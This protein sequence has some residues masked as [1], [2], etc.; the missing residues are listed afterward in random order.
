MNIRMRMGSALLAAALLSGTAA[1][2]LAAGGAGAQPAVTGSISATLRVDYDQRLSALADR[3]V[4]A[5]LSQKNGPSLGDIPL[6]EEGTVAL[7]GGKTAQVL[8]RSRDGGEV[9]GTVLPGN[10]SLTVSDLPQGTYT[11]T[12]N[13][14]G[15]TTYTE[16]ITLQDYSCHLIVGTG[17]ATFT[18]GDVDGDGK[19][20]AKDQ[21]AISEA[22]GSQKREDVTRYDL[23]GDGI[24]DIIDLAYVSRQIKAQGG[25]ELASTVM[26]AP[27]VDLDALADRLT[28][29]GTTVASGSLA[30]LFVENGQGAVLI[31]QKDG[32]PVTLEITPSS[33]SQ[34]AAGLG[35]I[36]LSSQEGRGAVLAGSAQVEYSD[37]S[38]ETIAFDQ[39]LPEGVHA[40]SRT[41]G[42]NVI[43]ISL[44]KRVPVKKVTITVTKTDGGDFVSL[45]TIQFLKDIVPENPVAPNSVVRGLTAEP[46]NEQ[47]DLK[48]GPLPNVEGYQVDYWPSEDNT[49]RKSLPVDVT[50]AT[51]TGL[52]NLTEYTFVVTPT[53]EGWA[54]KAS[55][56][57]T[58]TPQPA[59]AP[60]APDM[61]S[62]TEGDGELSI[63]WKESK[64]ATYYEVYY[65]DQTGA[66]PAAYQLAASE[67]A[68][69][70]FVLTGLTNGTLYS[71]YIVAG[72]EIGKSGP[73]RIAQGTPKAVVYERPE[74]IPTAGILDNSKIE[75]IQLA[76]KGNYHAPAYTA[77]A[78]FKP[79]NMIDGNYRTHWTASTNFMRNEHVICTFTEPVDLSTA[80]WVPRLDGAF[81]TYLRA[82]SVRVW[83][84]GEDLNGA[85]HLL[86]PDPE[87]GGLDN[88]GTS[89]AEVGTWPNLPN[90]ATV[91]TSKFGI[92]PF[93][94]VTDVVKISLAVEQKG[95][96][97]VSLS[98]LMFME[99]DPAHSL[100][101]NIAALFADEIRTQLAGGVDQAQIDALR[102]RLNSEERNYYLYP[103][104]LDDE[105]DLAEELLNGGATSGAVLEGIESRSGSAP[106]NQGQGGSI[107]QPLGA[108]S[109]AGQEITVYAAGI[110]E[111]ETVT[112][113]ATQYNAE[114]SQWQAQIGTLSN[115][116]N[117]LLVPK[118]GSQN[119]PRGGSLYLSYSG[120][121]PESI[122]LHIRRAE[123]IPML[124]LSNWYELDETARRAAIEAYAA[125]LDAYVQS[126]IGSVN[127]TTN[128]LNVTELSLP[129]VLLSLP[130]T[131]VR[132][133]TGTAGANRADQIYDSIL[134][135]EDLMHI[136]KT[137]QG[138]D[139]TYEASDMQTRQN[140]RC[141]QMFAGAFM[142]AA[143]SHIGIGYGSCG[144]MVCGK[145]IEQLSAS[146]GA[147][148]LFGWGIAHELGHNMDKLGKAEITNNIYSIMAQTFD[149]ADNTLPS[150]LEKSNK[151]AAAFQKA[152][153][154]Y[155]GASNDVFVQLAMYWQLHLAY[156]GAKGEAHGPMW[157]YN[158][159]FKDWKANTYAAPG[160][161]YDDRVALTAS[162]VTQTDLTE[163][164]TRWGMQLSGETVAALS[165]YA[166]E[167][168]AIWYLNDQSRRDRLNGGAQTQ[169]GSLS[170]Q[171]ELANDKEVTLT[172]TP[173]GSG[174]SRI[175]GYEI[176]RNGRSIAFT[177]EPT[178][179]DII[180]S[181]NH[182]TYA[183]EVVA[184]DILGNEAGRASSREIRV[185]YDQTVPA[186][187][188]TLERTGDTAVFT[189]TDPAAAAVS[190]LKLKGENLPTSGDFTVLVA[191]KDEGSGANE[192]LKTYTARTGS[193]DAGNQA[194]DEAASYVAYFWK[195]GTGGA[196]TRI[197]T[198][199]AVTVTVTGVPE[200]MA[201]SDIQLISYA[202]DDVAFLEG[203]TAGLLR[204]DYHYQN[205]DGSDEVIPAGTLVIV[206]T[207]RG[208]PVYN[209]VKIEGRFTVTG[210][211]GE[212][213]VTERDV[214]GYALLFAEIPEDGAVSDISD[215][216]FLFVPDVQR[217]AELQDAKGHN[218]SG[219][220][221]L[222][223]Q[224][225]AV[226]S[227]SDQPDGSGGQRTTAVTV[228]IDAPGGDSLPTLVLEGG[229]Q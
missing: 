176:R 29:S 37:G 40:L 199:D 130:A 43:T 144:G 137:T 212:T 220:N 1:P 80:F 116:R 18:L 197:W 168:R 226:L 117:I 134:A 101:D 161:P 67:L 42:S 65:T 104:I 64:S 97:Q 86:V 127:Q 30:G 3:K 181:G 109:K 167:P 83:Y 72:N 74:G 51:V 177:S 222:P 105:L 107:L 198:Y 133:N 214:D 153:Q 228:W 209:D 178:Y 205:G 227:R 93:G 71:V 25:A 77:D 174:L 48:W 218:C 26:L 208:D 61:V 32:G 78:P 76:D 195:P 89:N 47:V 213:K 92:L 185:A 124:E 100:P 23:N 163:F 188:Y 120:T 20:D 38:K 112:V 99:Y 55:A 58:A 66:E 129:S 193:F 56:P 95:Y 52:E 115:G 126:K 8:L 114:A 138:I 98:E 63:G 179:Q 102:A 84:A 142:Y 206:G 35:A 113:Y 201:D 145:P 157:F 128:C 33:G 169:L 36:Q 111:G 17:D 166:S 146:A 13:G 194:A 159:F 70:R 140:I 110:P 191:V 19:V 82:Y 155:P 158:Q 12:F 229:E 45:K 121:S 189:I 150:R 154:Q 122:R 152:A 91:S 156:D 106:S 172:I 139:K 7:E 148:Q 54:G 2:A 44:G 4:T 50:K 210:A 79:E 160:L 88:G 27:P 187:A 123:K 165:G 62:I 73:S 182:R 203:G 9:A 216:L 39:T 6:W 69:T 183:Y 207:Y 10:L 53:G 171:A 200:S 186:D 68:G 192:G 135:W 118:I 5:T 28:Q 184:Y 16:D 132:D 162:G 90:F 87:R 131:A 81:P 119:T 75:S 31:P 221:L 22:L 34:L 196:D 49:K 149:G 85:G 190:G 224:M 225:R 164:F 41:P 143:G 170:V 57:V 24:V 202:G 219:I 46:G 173:S 15:Y 151:Y 175:Q 96:D 103:E 108:A 21:E 217:E 94:P 141:M 204:D 136:C 125:E 215:G 147:N 180:G 11:L 223:S 211:D 14:R 60:T 59:A